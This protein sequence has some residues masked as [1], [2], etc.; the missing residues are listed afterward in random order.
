MSKFIPQRCE[1][2]GLPPPHYEFTCPSG[3]DSSSVNAFV[4]CS[5]HFPS[6]FGLPD[7]LAVV[8][9]VYGKKR[10]KEECARALVDMLDK[11]E[12]WRL[13]GSGLWEE[14]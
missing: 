3:G 5:A 4:D 8:R 13:K 12:R 14:S 11:V 6:I 2:L 9:N 1:Q 10:A 7:P